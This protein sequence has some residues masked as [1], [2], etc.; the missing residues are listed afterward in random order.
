MLRAERD[1]LVKNIGKQATVNH[2]PTVNQSKH[3]RL[4]YRQ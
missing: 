3:P 2:S 4:D 1:R